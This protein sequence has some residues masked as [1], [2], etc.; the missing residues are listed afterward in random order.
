MGGHLPYQR[1]RLR[2]GNQLGVDG[3]VHID[4][5]STQVSRFDRTPGRK[6][7]SRYYYCPGLVVI[8]E[9]NEV[10][11]ERQYRGEEHE[12][13][14]SRD[15]RERI[16]PADPTWTHRSSLAHLLTNQ[17]ASLFPHAPR[18]LAATLRS[19][20]LSPLRTRNK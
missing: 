11:R 19:P 13:V 8:A 18:Q 9:D 16:A 20:L 2:P 17:P 1:R 7:D 10:G 5:D 6:V 4:F 12:Q 14:S 3:I 15:A